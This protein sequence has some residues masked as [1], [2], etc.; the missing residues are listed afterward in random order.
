MVEEM[1]Y[2]INFLGHKCLVHINPAQGKLI[3]IEFVDKQNE[4]QTG[5]S[6]LEMLKKMLLFIKINNYLCDEG[7]IVD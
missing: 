2:N 5:D 1:C 4:I 3:R 6:E 7:F